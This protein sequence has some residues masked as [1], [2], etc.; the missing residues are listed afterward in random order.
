MCD[1]Y[2]V[3]VSKNALG[4]LP[5]LPSPQFCHREACRVGGSSGAT[6]ETSK[7]NAGRETP[8]VSSVTKTRLA[9]VVDTAHGK[10]CVA[11]GSIERTPRPNHTANATKRV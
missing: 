4:T 3:C 6:G 7:V 11:A 1:F 8:G 10:H 5:P 2:F 9:H